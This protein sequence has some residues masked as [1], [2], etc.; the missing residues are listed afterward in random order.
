MLRVCR[1]RKKFQKPLTE[2]EKKSNNPD[3]NE[4]IRI[5]IKIFN[6]NELTIELSNQRKSAG[7]TF[8]QVLIFYSL[9][10]FNVKAKR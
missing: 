2:A 4:P 3:S 10:I 5:L 9:L 7:L 8:V 6:E 1:R